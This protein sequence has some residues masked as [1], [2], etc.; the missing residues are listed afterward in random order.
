MAVIILVLFMTAFGAVALLFKFGPR[1]FT[2]AFWR[3]DPNFQRD[4]RALMRLPFQVA[5]EVFRLAYAASHAVLRLA[6]AV[7]RVGLILAAVLGVLYAIVWVVHAMW[8]AT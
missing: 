2:P 6:Y 1:A 3:P 5:H 7:L 4:L 8:R